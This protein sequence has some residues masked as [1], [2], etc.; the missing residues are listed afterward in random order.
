MNNPYLIQGARF[1]V[2]ID[3][4]HLRKGIDTVLSFSYMGS[5]EFEF[6]A[7]PNSLKRIRDN[8]HEYSYLQY[9][10][11]GHIDKTLT[12]FG[13]YMD[14]NEICSMIDSIAEVRFH[15]KE[16]CDLSK[17]LTGSKDSFAN[18]HWWDIENDFMFWKYN[19]DFETQFKKEIISTNISI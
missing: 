4:S 11:P 9:S 3:T 1:N 10:I 16:R 8:I 5:A 19:Q 6:G 14:L 12:I 2:N 18:D 17:Y 7:L 13:R 15:L